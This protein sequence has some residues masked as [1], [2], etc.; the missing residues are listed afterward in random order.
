ME[1]FHRQKEEETKL[2]VDYFSPGTLPLGE[3]RG[4]YQTDYLTNGGQEIPG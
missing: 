1:G 3:G 4:S 2:R